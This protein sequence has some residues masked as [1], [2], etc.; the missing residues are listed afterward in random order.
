MHAFRLCL[1][2]TATSFL[3]TGAL[4]FL[5]AQA[6]PSHGWLLVANKG[7][8]TLGIID[9]AAGKQIAVIPVEGVTGHEVAASPDGKLAF[10]PIYGN[11][12]VGLPGTNGSKIMVIDMDS[13]KLTTQ[14]DIGHGVRPH[15][16]V[17]NPADGLLYVTSEV[18]K[19]IQVIDPH[20]LKI[21]GTVPTG[22]PESHMLAISSDGKR[23]Y[24]A[25]VGPGTVSAIDL[26]ARRVVAVIPV[27][28][29]IQRIAISTDNRWVFT[30]DQDEP[31]L[32]VIDTASNS[33]KQWVK[34][35]DVAYGT[36]ASHDGKW[37][38][39]TQPKTSKIAVLDLATMKIAHMIDVPA[40]PQEIVVRPDDRRAYVSCIDKGQVA[41][42][43]LQD[44]KLDRVIDAGKGADGLAWAVRP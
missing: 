43:D 29:S 19:D 13:R 30:A 41:V 24:T 42:L 1:A 33:V 8:G 11:S 44:W 28:H 23:G 14:I 22:Q 7:E 25:N 36:A 12:G 10:V 26:V 18:D 39:I 38:L 3:L 6:A 31:R 21:V 4:A 35:P 5:H 15:C 34:L 20:S 37:L 16:A 40:K 27:A 9:L 2:L 32:A 17:F